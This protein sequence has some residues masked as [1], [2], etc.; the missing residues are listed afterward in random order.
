MGCPG[1]FSREAHQGRAPSARAIDRLA[2]RRARAR[3]HAAGGSGPLLRVHVHLRRR[4][5]LLLLLRALLLPE[6]DGGCRALLVAFLV[7]LAA[8]D[9]LLGLRS[10]RGERR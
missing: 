1:S 3:G 10:L 8:K 7:V 4:L 6:Q 5:L 2:L 9:R